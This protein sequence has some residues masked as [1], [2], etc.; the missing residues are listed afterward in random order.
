[1][2]LELILT[3]VFAATATAVLAGLSLWRR[4]RSHR[5]LVKSLQEGEGA[6]FRHDQGASKEALLT[7]LGRRFNR[8]AA[9]DSRLK[10]VLARAG[11]DSR[12]AP[13]TFSAARVWLMASL[14]LL[15]AVLAYGLNRPQEEII[16]IAIFGLLIG[17]LA[18]KLYV[19]GR[20]RKR[21]KRIQ[22][23][24]PDAL[25]LMV[26]CV[27]AGVGID[28]AILRVADELGL[29]HPDLAYEFQVVNQRVNAGIPRSEAMR[30][31]VGRTNVEDLRSVVT[32][33]IQSEKLGVS[34]GRVLRVSSDSLRTK[35]R[36][37]AEQAARK[38]PIKMLIPMIFFI[39]PA[40]MA[41]ILG[42]AGFHIVEAL[43]SAA[44]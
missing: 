18:P 10:L 20:G 30:E 14:P 28:A 40:L 19:L 32:T 27:E 5:K 22:R 15:L 33:L 1:M 8:G 21:S 31:M 16:L 4:A 26:V 41:F 17:W 38:A 3:L 6:T 35:R 34:I 39:L 37:F 24:L 25:D 13:L 12:T 11:W 23:S 7:R 43:R 44:P 9:R 36:Q 2:S 42:P 29:S